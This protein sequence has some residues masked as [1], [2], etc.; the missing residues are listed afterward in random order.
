MGP[1]RG[2]NDSRWLERALLFTFVAHLLAMLTMALFL[3]PALPGGGSGDAL[4]RVMYVAQ[5]P[6]LVRLGWSGWQLTALSDLLMAC[7]LLVTPWVPKRAA[8][9]TLLC[10][11]FALGPDQYFQWQW[12]V[13]GPSLAW[14]AL[15]AGD[16]GPYLQFEAEAFRYIAGWGPVGYLGAAVGWTWCFA[17]AGVWS[18]GLTRLSWVTWGAFAAA[19]G[20][21]LFGPVGLPAPWGVVVS[22]GN[23][24][25]FILLMVWLAWVSELVFRR[26]RPYVSDGAQA[27]WR[28]PGT[29]PV[30]RVCDLLANSR[31][32]HALFRY[33]PRLAMA[34]DIAD[35]IYVNYL[36]DADA[37]AN[38]VPAPLRIQRLGPGGR[39]AMFSTLTYRHGHFGPRV[40]GPLRTLWPSPIQSNWRVYVDDPAT[41]KAGVH[42]VTTAITSVPHALA[43][44]LLSEGVPMHVPARARLRRRSDGELDVG[45][46]PGGGSAPDL[47]AR[48]RPA[49]RHPLPRLWSECFGTWEGVLGYCV[50]Q[51]RA[52]SVQ[53]W[54]GRVTRQEIDLGIPL[55]SCR[56]LEGQVTSAA[57]RAIVGD[58]QPLCFHVP[59][60]RF[61]YRGEEYDYGLCVAEG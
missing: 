28:H 37:L 27:P 53:P 41:G 34:S 2:H 45:I 39:Y 49:G 30:A 61:L 22:V 51:D 26:A 12:D 42:F 43:A 19:T 25:A 1:D 7:A 38:W 52:L 33:C 44:R 4:S 23:G 60:V 36:V 13:R 16:L 29:G 17:A 5:H 11:L 57:A 54:D 47:T 31:F 9:L 15:I 55:D 14:H 32:L 10:T 40:F 35:V 46:D 56:P 58:A 21:V 6:W 3:A 50:P 48:L 59:A 24:V 8:A 18:R 20:I